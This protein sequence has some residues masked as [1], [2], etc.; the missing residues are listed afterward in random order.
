MKF[1]RKRKG[2]YISYY[3]QSSKPYIIKKGLFV[4]SKWSLYHGADYLSQHDT[5][6][7][8]A[9]EAEFHAGERIEVK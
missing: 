9:Q 2:F 5:K 1:R 6:R 7:E 8:C 3:N 4:D